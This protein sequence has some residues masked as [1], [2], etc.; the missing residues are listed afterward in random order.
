VRSNTRT[1]ATKSGNM[2]E[3][4]ASSRLRGFRRLSVQQRLAMLGRVCGF[5]DD[6]LSSLRDGT[7]L[8]IDQAVNMVENA[9]GIFGLPLG[10]GTNLLVN[11]RDYIVPLAVEEPSIIAALSKAAL[12]LRQGG[13]LRAE[14]DEPVMIGQIHVVELSDPEAAADAV[15]THAA[16]IVELSNRHAS[17][18]VKRG[19]G[20]ESV[21]AR[22][23]ED[24][25]CPPFLVVHLLMDVR[26]AMGANAINGV[27]EHVAPHI[28]K[29]TG[30]RANMRILSNYAD[31]RLA[32][33]SF[34][35]PV[36]H[37]ATDELDG[38][39]VAARLEMA[40]RFAHLDV[41]RAVT[42]NKGFF[43][44]TSA[45]ALA[46]GQDWRAIEAG[47]HAFAARDG[48]Y[49]SLTSFIV[50]GDC[51]VGRCE[52][53]MQVGLM[54]GAVR[55]HPAV[56]IL[57]EIAGIESA[58]DLAGLLVAVGLTQNLAACNALVTVGI[59]RGHMALHARSVAITAG[60][61]PT[62]VAEVVEEM[63]R[64]SDVRVDAAE[65]IYRDIRA[66]RR[67]A[68]PKEFTVS[69][70]NPGK[71]ILFGEHA[72]VYGR[73]GITTP[74]E[75]V[76]T[77]SFSPDEDGPRL[78]RPEFPTFAPPRDD[79]PPLRSLSEAFDV[80]LTMYELHN[81]KIAV[82]IDTEIVPGAGLGSS[83]A[84]SAAL[85]RACRKARGLPYSPD[86]EGLFQEVQ[87]L[88]SVFH[89]DPSGLDAAT[90]LACGAVWFEKGPPRSIRELS[91]PV[92]VRGVVCVVEP[93]ASTKRMV[94]QVGT[95]MRND[96]SLT[97]AILSDIASVTSSARDGIE[98]G[99]WSEVGALMFRNH[100]LLVR[101]GVSTPR[102]DE[103]VQEL[104]EHGVLGAKMTGAGGGGAVVAL[105]PKE[106][107][108]DLIAV[109]E[110]RFQ[111]LYTFSLGAAT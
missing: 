5:S 28:E 50:E 99:E 69:I 74:L 90:T 59:Q 55:A 106:D 43:N 33:A 75:A 35:L 63:N 105:L 68:P 104:L 61:P 37:L 82:S 89:G 30:G 98:S 101:L 85:C 39:E 71:A 79:D 22:V 15:M 102:L 26:E 16:E 76:T 111:A 14:A 70:S 29:L 94:E 77:V 25:V 31:R 110:K 20:V 81:A 62:D 19:G 11:D 2:A 51:L 54:G 9:V 48:R 60:I 7:A 27:C 103:A 44:G 87:Q 67:E 13:G 18:M 10:I 95:L 108:E 57:L 40:W 1:T 8:T 32:R 53:P 41:Y 83:A 21:E 65:C 72:V 4:R 42:H 3:Q 80:A 96:P 58:K 100:E 97:G 23:F 109:L 6:Q 92:P 66:R 88:E 34:R 86:A 17:S 64:S 12:V 47:G 73:P 24:D 107:G 38:A 78:L 52:M 56:P 93:G 45:C 36:S 84:F 49:R 91:V 46:L